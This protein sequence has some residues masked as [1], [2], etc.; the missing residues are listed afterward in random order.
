M[1]RR[2]VM[3]LL[4]SFGTWPSAALAQTSRRTARIAV[5]M[6][7]PEGDPEGEECLR[8]F[9]LALREAGWTEGENARLEVRWYAGE[10]GRADAYARELVDQ[11]P[12]VIVVNHSAGL[13]AVKPLT[14][15]IPIVFVVLADPVGAG[16]VASFA[17]PGGNVTGFSTFDPEIAGKWLEALKEVA[18]RTERVGIIGDSAQ[19]DFKSLWR[20]MEA[21]GPSFGL[22]PSEVLGHDGPT[23]ERAVQAFAQEPLG[24]LVVVPSPINMARRQS[25][26]SVAAR[27]RLPAVYAFTLYAKSGGLLS[28]GFSSPDLFRR[29]GAYVSRILNGEKPGDLPVQAPTK[30]ELAINLKTAKTLG[31]DVPYSLL[32]RAD[33]VID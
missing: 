2:D 12:D 15:S 1:N 24:G 6:V 21:L 30:F 25:I 26:I 27:H 18:P 19:P 13:T 23:I 4:G 8:A 32:A 31:L 33:E 20:T 28:Y 22:R 7:Y 29:S 16:H 3:M 14:T 17:R 11:A 5:L 9:R 10:R